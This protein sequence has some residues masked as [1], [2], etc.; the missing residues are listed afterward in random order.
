MSGVRGSADPGQNYRRPGEYDRDGSHVSR[1]STPEDAWRGQEVDVRVVE[2]KRAH[3]G[4]VGARDGA[5]KGLE[6]VGHIY[7]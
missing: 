7:R 5:R 1:G 3:T 6:Q 2:V 4:D